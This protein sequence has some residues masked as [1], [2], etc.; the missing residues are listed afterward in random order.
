MSTSYPNYIE[1]SDSTNRFEGFVFDNFMLNG[2]TLTESNW[3]KAGRFETKNLTAPVF[4]E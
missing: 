4:K 1:C 3:I 2:M